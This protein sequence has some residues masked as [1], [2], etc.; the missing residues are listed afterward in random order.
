MLVK[1][2]KINSITQETRYCRDVLYLKTLQYILS[3]LFY[4]NFNLWFASQMQDK[5]SHTLEELLLTI[6]T[7]MMRRCSVCKDRDVV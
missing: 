5:T 2:Q 1:S 4:G 6:T 3:M 7:I